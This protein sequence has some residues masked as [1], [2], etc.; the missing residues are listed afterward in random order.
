MFD[1]IRYSADKADEWNAFV[2][3]SKN[4]TFL[5]DRRYMDYHSDRFLDHSLMFYEKGRL[6]AVMPANDDKHGTL[7][8]HQGL[9]YGGLIMD[10]GCRAAKVRDLF[11]QMNDYLRVEGFHRVVYNHI[12]YIYSSLPAEED[13]F[14]LTNVCRATIQSRDVASVV[15]LHRRLPFSEL[16]RRG[17]KKAVASR[18]QVIESTDYTSFWDVLSSNLMERFHASPVHSLS[19]IELLSSRFPQNIKLYVV[20]D[21][22]EVIGGT[23]FYISADTVKTQYISTNDRGRRV[24]ALDYLFSCLLDKYESEGFRFFD[25][26]TSNRVDTDD[27][28]D[29]LIFQKEGFGGRA[30]CYD[31]YEWHL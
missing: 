18:L 27:L 3:A 17:I 9:T 21:G 28:N 23:V 12:P 29:P 31:H 22:G 11:L 10:K 6:Y 2:A 19:E 14:A 15:D 25:F 13:L 30:V 5:F 20:T 1:I 8:S 7:F 16:R 4:G 26:G 24:G